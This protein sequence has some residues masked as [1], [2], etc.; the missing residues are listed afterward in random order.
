[1]GSLATNRLGF[2][3]VCL[4]VLV[5]GFFFGLVKVFIG[6]NMLGGMLGAFLY[7]MLCVT[8]HNM[9]KFK[10]LDILVE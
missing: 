1:M 5:W 7:V 6:K 10:T 8:R 9:I 2:L 3:V 4:G